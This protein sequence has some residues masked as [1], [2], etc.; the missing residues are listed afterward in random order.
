MSGLSQLDD[1]LKL[2]D[3]I[4]SLSGN[5]DADAHSDV[6]D[7]FT[8]PPTSAPHTP[9]RSRSQTV[10]KDVWFVKPGGLLDLSRSEL[11]SL[12]PNIC[13]T[14]ASQNQVRQIQLH[15]NPIASIPIA[16]GAFASTL[17]YLSLAHAQ[18]AGES[19]ITETIELPAL[20]EL[21]LLS[22]QITSLAPMTKFLNAP[23]LEKL[24]VTLNRMSSLPTDLKQA[25]PQLSVLLAASNQL[26]ELN[27]EW[28]RGLK[29][30]D[31]S[32]NDISQL[33]PRLGLLGGVDG[34]Q[35]LELAGNRFKVP[36][37]SILERGTEAT[38][39]WL[40]GRLPVEEMAA[41]RTANGEE[42]GDDVD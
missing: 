35:R 18:L 6:D 24:D 15:H 16:L 31:A 42:S 10:V 22:N 34:L 8:T 7:D 26:S 28:I 9:S 21:S 39:R 40:R 12:N 13:S 2:T 37:W 23:A 17:S 19:Y 33:N 4:G 41:W 11:S 14:I 3:D 30:V 20:R 29:I 1:K 25:F 36:R 38:L 32:S 5:L 27:P